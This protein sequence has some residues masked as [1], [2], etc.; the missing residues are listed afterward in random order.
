MRTWSALQ[1]RNNRKISLV[2]TMGYLHEGHLSLIR[3]ARKRTDCIVV[4]IYVNPTQFAAGEDL[5][6]YPRDFSRDERRCEHEGVEAVFYPSDDDMYQPDHTTYVLSGE[7]GRKLCGRSRPIHFR[8][9]ITIVAK[10]FNI[11]QPH[12][13]VFGQKDAQQSII[14]KKMVQDLNFDIEMI[15]AP[16]VREEDGLAMSSRNKYL[17]ETERRQAAALYQSLQMAEDEYKNGNNDLNDI[18]RKIQ[19][20][21]E[22]KSSGKIDYVECVNTADLGTA[23]PQTSDVLLALAVFFGNTRLIDNTVLKQR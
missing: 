12:I 9:V 19:Q 8:G 2:P 23:D 7:M 14:L 18:C 22:Q 17:S 4:S 3:E 10:L 5:G 1:R 20:L 13:A 6:H 16:I 11:I 21:I 15:I